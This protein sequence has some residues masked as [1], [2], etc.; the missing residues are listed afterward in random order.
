MAA[1]RRVVVPRDMTRVSFHEAAE[2]KRMNPTLKLFALEDARG[3][4][5][6]WRIG[7]LPASEFIKSSGLARAAHVVFKTPRVKVFFPVL[8]LYFAVRKVELRE[9]HATVRAIL[10]AVEGVARQ[11]AAFHI[12]RDLAHPHASAGEVQAL[13]R[14]LAVCHLLCKRT[15]GANHVYVW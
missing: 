5:L 9:R 10:R 15:G 1:A 4:S 8:G 7:V 13:L 2:L 14:D 3:R 12:V 11:A 6:C